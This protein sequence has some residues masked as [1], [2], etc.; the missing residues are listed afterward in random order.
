MIGTRARWSLQETLDLDHH[1]RRLLVA[2]LEGLDE[3]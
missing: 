3:P 2:T 1:E